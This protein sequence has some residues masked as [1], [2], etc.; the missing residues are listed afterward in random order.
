MVFALVDI[1][2]IIKKHYGTLM[3]DAKLRFII[4]IFLIIPLLTSGYFI[5]NEK[6]LTQ[7]AVNT[8]ITA[9]AIFT[10]LLLNVIF[11]L[12]DIAD[13]SWRSNAKI[14]EKRRKLLK[15][16]YAN[17]LYSLFI[18]IIILIL[19]VVTVISELWNAKLSLLLTISILLYFLIF[20][21]LTTLLMIL[22]RLFVLLFEHLED[23]ENAN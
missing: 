16:L 20:H 23:A 9:F 11:I 8:L 22:K 15:H 12:F 3:E 4:L 17:S 2:E 14:D 21:F 5:W 7:N 13:K 6:L 1:R 10:G 18:S 19:L